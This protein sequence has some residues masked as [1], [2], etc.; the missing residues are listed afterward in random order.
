MDSE[1]QAQL[2]A[3]RTDLDL[4]TEIEAYALMLAGYLMTEYEFKRLQQAHD[5][6]GEAG[7]WGGF[8]INA[9][10]Q[11]WPF[12]A[13][14]SIAQQAPN[15]LDPRRRDLG[16]Q[17]QV[18]AQNVFRLIRLDPA[19]RRLVIALAAGLLIVLSGLVWLFWDQ[20]IGISMTLGGLIVLIAL[21]VAAMLVP[22]LKWLTPEKAGRSMA[23]KVALAVLG[24]V[25]S[26][27]QC[28]VLD[29]RL[30]A[31]GSLQRLLK[32]AG[33]GQDEH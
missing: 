15:S 21:S 10:R 32:L 23:T 3:I 9:K 4:F 31:R 22:A 5:K 8:E 14:E 30:L 11:D 26:Q 6:Q 16:L 13:L 20:P 1:L 18:G 24:Y 25:V 33:S 17:L 7:D 28:R 12:L 29:K 27:F 2:A 19:L